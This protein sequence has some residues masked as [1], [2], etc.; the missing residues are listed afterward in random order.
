[1]G[2]E[3]KM[4]VYLHDVLYGNEIAGPC[5]V[6]GGSFT[7]LIGKGWDLQVDLQGDGIV[8]RSN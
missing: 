1:M 6:D 3:G 8:R 7:W 2:E 5:I 4:P